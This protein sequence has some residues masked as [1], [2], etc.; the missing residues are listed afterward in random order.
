MLGP[1]LSFSTVNIA[2]SEWWC[3]AKYLVSGQAVYQHK[4]GKQQKHF[5]S[6]L[7]GKGLKEMMLFTQGLR[8]EAEWILSMGSSGGR[9]Q[10]KSADCPS[11]SCDAELSYSCTQKAPCSALS[12]KILDQTIA[13]SSCWSSWQCQQYSTHFK[14]KAGRE[15][16][17]WRRGRK[18]A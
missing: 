13:L 15:K 5:F 3:K 10:L 4:L 8:I 17:V 6:L 2:F 18:S 7:F 14:V 16:T 12:L 11:Q 9:F 1:F